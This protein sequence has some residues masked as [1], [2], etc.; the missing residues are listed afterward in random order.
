MLLDHAGNVTEGPG[1]NVF[2]VRG[3]RVVTSDHGVLHGITRQTVIDMAQAEGLTVETRALPL[4]ELLEADE[5]FLSS[6]GGGVIPVA[7]VDD[8]SFS[9]GAAGPVATRLR[10]RY[11]DWIEQDRFRTPVRYVS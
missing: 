10:Q 5:V 11:F 6:S 7:R 4:D 2:A 9:N 1:F 8:R 3:G